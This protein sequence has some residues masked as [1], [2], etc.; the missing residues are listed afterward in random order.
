MSHDPV[1]RLDAFERRLAAA[2]RQSAG[3][4]EGAA[5][6]TQAVLADPDY[7][8]ALEA[9]AEAAPWRVAVHRRRQAAGLVHTDPDIGRL[10]ARIRATA[11]AFEPWIGDRPATWNEVDRVLKHDPDR[12]RREAAWFAAVPLAQE[13]EPDVQRLMQ[14]RNERARG[15][16]DDDFP[17][18][19]LAADELTVLEFMTACDELEPL[20]RPAFEQMLA[21]LRDRF[22]GETLEPWDI[23]YGLARIEPAP[24][25]VRPFGLG[26]MAEELGVPLVGAEFEDPVTAQAALAPPPDDP[27]R[28]AATVFDDWADLGGRL[29]AM[30]RPV[31]P[32]AAAWTTG[33][34]NEAMRRLLGESMAAEPILD[35]PGTLADRA[36]IA[37]RQVYGLRRLMAASL[38]ELLAYESPGADLHGLW[39]EIHE[40]YLGFPRH[41]E[42]LWAAEPRFV[43]APLAG[44]GLVLGRVIAA[45][46]AEWLATD[47]KRVITPAAGAVIRREL[48]EP[49]ARQA[50]ESA[51]ERLTGRIPDPDAYVRATTVASPE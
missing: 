21:W 33:T 9:A 39:C 31:E 51:V 12:A 47:H 15:L 43:A 50:G 36:W 27:P 3:D 44:P 2:A 37:W 24:G 18:A 6:A 23:A 1:S 20:T 40:H 29:H 14:L 46:L 26:A 49:G 17:A 30:H 34:W 7:A 11:R 45:Q 28:D 22:D 8:A 5:A 25:S 19:A 42:R 10:E 35:R 41:P 16:L 13:I 38:F 4:A 48:W 32:P